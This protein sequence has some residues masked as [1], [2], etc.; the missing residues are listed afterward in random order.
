MQKPSMSKVV[1]ERG[2]AILPEVLPRNELTGLSEE[3]SDGSMR[4]SRAGVRHAM[5]LP[6]VAALARGPRL[7]GIAREIL[8]GSAS[9]FRATLFDKSA[10]ANWLV[11]WHQD[12]ALPLE[13]KIETEGWGPWSVKEGVIYAHAPADALARVIALRVHLDDSD[14]ENGPLRVLPGSHCFGVLTDERIH[15]LAAEVPALDCLVAKGGVLAMRPLIVHASS[16]SQTAQ[17]RRVLHIEYADSMRICD[18][19]ELATA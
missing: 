17:S 11:V 10:E 9:P 13:K 5:N 19:L 14:A 3:F 4:R 8:G 18:G 16:K 7:M 2:F 12:T 1:E 15:T 6:R